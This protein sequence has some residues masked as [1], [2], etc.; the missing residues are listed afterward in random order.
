MGK[1]RKYIEIE[2]Y[3]IRTSDLKSEQ[4]GPSTDKNIDIEKIGFFSQLKPFFLRLGRFFL[5]LIYIYTHYKWYV[6][7]FT[8]VWRV[9]S[10]FQIENRS[11]W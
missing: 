4:L 2:L 11:D 9:F 1:G 6:I 3:N 10:H 7:R 5:R 8:F